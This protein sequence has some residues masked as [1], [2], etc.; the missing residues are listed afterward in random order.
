MQHIKRQALK[1]HSIA[2]PPLV[3]QR[4]IATFLDRETERIDT[5]IEK[6]ERLVELL[7]EKRSALVSHVV[8]KGLDAEAEMHDSGVKWL[9]E[10]PAGWDVVRLKFLTSL[11]TSGP[12]GWAEYYS[13][14]GPI[15]L[16][17][18][19]LSRGSLDLDLSEVEHVNPPEDAEGTRTRLE[20]NDLL[21]S[22][23]AYIG[24]I[25][26]IPPDLGEAYVNQHIALVRPLLDERAHSRWLGYCLLSRVGKSQFGE[27]LYGG[28]KDGLSLQDVKDLQVLLPP[29]DE[30][31]TIVN[32]LD[33]KT[34]QIDALIERV[35]D[36]IERL[37]EYRTALI[38][39][40][41]TGEIDVRDAVYA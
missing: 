12:R 10:I 35:E 6:K 4:A 5:L 13:E 8:T 23:T 11:V 1:D 9:G 33:E 34:A 18:G 31:R 7:E 20:G 38:S 28:T 3:E 39:T 15:F 36:G 30:Q 17:V 32:H 27:L 29:L 22:I 41:V 14:E 16:Q 21:L 19:N 26:V 37:R 25:G 2:L 40:A 24:S